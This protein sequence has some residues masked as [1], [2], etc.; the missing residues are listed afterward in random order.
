MI[1]VRAPS[2]SSTRTSSPRPEAFGSLT[3]DLEQVD[4]GT[5]EITEDGTFVMSKEF[6]D[7]TFHYTIEGDSLMLT[8]VL[9]K[10]MKA[11]ARAHPLEFTTA[12]WALAMSYPGQVWKRVDC[13]GWC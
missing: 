5:Y 4:D 7:V 1:S 8:P 12:G 11:E 2:I 6:P 9:T 3:E 10:E 13:S